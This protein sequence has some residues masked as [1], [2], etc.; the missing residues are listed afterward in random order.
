[1]KKKKPTIVIL[2]AGEGKRLRPHTSTIPKTLLDVG[3][4]SLLEHILNNIE[5]KQ[6]SNV[7]IV[8]GY[9]G[10]KIK[11]KLKGKYKNLKIEY[12]ENSHY[13]G[14]DNLYSVLCARKKI[15][16][17]VVFVNGDTI[18]HKKVFAKILS[19]NKANC[20]AVDFERPIDGDAMRVH[21]D[22]SGKLVEI[23]KRISKKTH[24]DASGIYK[25]SKKAAG[26]YFELAE[27]YFSKGPRRGGFVVPL[28]TMKK[29]FS[30][31]LI[32]VEKKHVIEID[33]EKDLNNAQEKIKA[34]R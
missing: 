9:Q 4:C 30:L 22:S 25:L 3:K 5:S 18:F 16:S 20:I 6:V 27:K 17:D 28:R 8:I 10:Q 31:W 19:S 33:T 2:A 13:R 21:G 11:R 14:S 32:P 24:G 23:G 1:M 29:E 7:I 12:V 34:F 15:D 26:R